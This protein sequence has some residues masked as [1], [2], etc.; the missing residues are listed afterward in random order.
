M[1]ESHRGR[2]VLLGATGYTGRLT[3]QELVRAGVSPI[4]AGRNADAL[5]ALADDVADLNPRGTGIET[6]IADVSDPGSVRALLNGPDDVLIS[7]VGPFLQLGEPAVRAATECGAGYLDSCGEPGFIRRV[8]ED[9]GPAAHNSG[10]RLMPAFGYDYVPGALAATLAV[11]R[12]MIGERPPARV[13]VGYF[14]SGNAQPSSGTRASAAGVLMEPS[15][16]WHDG[17]LQA[18]RPG[19]RVR[20]FDVGNG[21]QWDALSV[22]G[23]EHLTLHRLAPSVT[24]V[25]VYLGWGGRLTRAASVA[26]V[27]TSTA[28]K[29]PGVGSA[30]GAFMRGMSGTG[31]TGGP[32]EDERSGS[33]SIA[34]AETFDADGNAQISVRVEGPSPYDL[35][36]SLL[37][38]GAQMLAHGTA[39]SVGALGPVDAF[40]IEAFVSGCMALGLSEVR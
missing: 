30:L 4:L 14:V 26:G 8:F 33:R 32:D 29:V 22:G 13:D 16:A 12:A 25:N 31:P 20:S 15:F 3:A 1:V 2:I 18:E 17:R 28:S 9:F 37:A 5:A 34:V 7:T 27:F 36:A 24:D 40:G 6:V 10:A 35:T 19:A 38:W 21:R 39:H 23:I 11:K